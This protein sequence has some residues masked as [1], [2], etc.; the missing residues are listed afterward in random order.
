MTGTTAA[1]R[2][3][4]ERATVATWGMLFGIIAGGAATATSGVAPWLSVLAMI[5]HGVWGGTLGAIAAQ[6]AEAARR[7]AR[8]AGGE[9]V[10]GWTVAALSSVALAMVAGAIAVAVLAAAALFWCARSARPRHAARAPSTSEPA[11]TVMIEATHIRKRFGA[12]W[13]LDGVTFRRDAPGVLVI[14]GENGSGKSTLLR[15]V[16]GVIEHDEGSVTIAGHL[17]EGDRERALHHLGYVPDVMDLPPHLSVKE[18][19]ALIAALKRAA[20]PTPASIERLGAAHLLHERLAALSLGQRRRVC[21]LAALTGEPR[22]LVLDEPTNGLDAAGL[23]MLAALLKERTA[24]GF[25]ALVAT[26]EDGFA[27]AVADEVLVLA[28]GRLHGS[29]PGPA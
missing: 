23:D 26:H 2:I 16:S 22:L 20:I 3:F 18:W 25:A 13:I 27:R 21:L 5:L 6:V 28:K 7:R 1:V 4:A 9:G 14:R 19:L 11:L 15:V 12:Q 24:A 17:L 29:S 10:A 8:A